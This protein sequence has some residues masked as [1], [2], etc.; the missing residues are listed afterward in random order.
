MRSEDEVRVHAQTSNQGMHNACD[1]AGRD[2]A[3]GHRHRRDDV[4]RSRRLNVLL[5]ARN[6]Q[7]NFNQVKKHGCRRRMTIHMDD[8]LRESS[9]RRKSLGTGTGPVHLPYRARRGTEERGGDW[10]N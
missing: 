9:R 4:I 6:V 5:E 10:S 1:R 2:A 7:F 3:D 8:S